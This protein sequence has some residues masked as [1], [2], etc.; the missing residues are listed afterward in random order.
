VK[1]ADGFARLAE[2][3]DYNRGVAFMVIR[4]T[5]RGQLTIRD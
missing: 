2:S 4:D 1:D 3:C 5:E